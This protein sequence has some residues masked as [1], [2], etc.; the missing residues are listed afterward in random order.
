MADLKKTRPIIA[1][2]LSLITPGLGQV[3][4]GKLKRG[5][6]F[7][8]FFEFSH[9]LLHLLSELRSKFNGFILFFAFCLTFFGFFI[10]VLSD[11]FRDV[12]RLRVTVRKPYHRWYIYVIISAVIIL[13]NEFILDPIL[14]DIKRFKAYKFPSI[15]M[16]PAILVGDRLVAD[17]K[18]YK[19]E[20]PERGDVIIFEYPKDP[21]KYFLKRVIG[22]EG[23]KVEITDNKVYINDRLIDDPWGYYEREKTYLKD[24]EN[25][26]PV[27]VPKGSL[28]VLGDNRH[29]SMDSRIFGFVDLT[30]VRAKALYIYWAKNKSRIGMQI[31]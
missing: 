20:K 22:L 5:I 25:F 28:F 6:I 1:L 19:E 13:I 16:Q 11:A 24:L 4:N 9:I 27:E 3:Y 12:K 17:R 2:L 7:F 29:N 18:I 23:D 21:S 14:P 30:K 26:G 15:S 31:K 8:W 10:Y